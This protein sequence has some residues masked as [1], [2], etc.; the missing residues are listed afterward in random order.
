[1]INSALDQF[2]FN[3]TGVVSGNSTLNGITFGHAYS[4]GTRTEMTF[5]DAGYTQLRAGGDFRYLGQVITEDYA[6][7]GDIVTVSG[8]DNFSTNLPHATL[9]DPGAFAEVVQPVSEKWT[10]NLGTRVDYVETEA[11]PAEANPILLS[12]G[13]PLAQDDILYAFYLTNKVKLDSHWTLD[14]GFGESQRPPTLMEPLFRRRVHQQS[15][16]WLDARHR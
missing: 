10:I 1:M 15:A 4:A 13:V 5:G 2:V 8:V 16:K 7:S 6:L 11:D 12:F 3:S 9:L 14:A